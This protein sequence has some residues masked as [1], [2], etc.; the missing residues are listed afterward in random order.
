MIH[1]L[2][3]DVWKDSCFRTKMMGDREH[4]F[5]CPHPLSKVVYGS[6]RAGLFTLVP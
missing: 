3:L 1:I 4:Q 6:D 2:Q 5:L